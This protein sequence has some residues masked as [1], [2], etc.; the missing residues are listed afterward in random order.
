[1]VRHLW[2]GEC[3]FLSPPTLTLRGGVSCTNFRMNIIVRFY[4]QHDLDLVALAK[5]PDF[6][7]DVMMKKALRAYVRGESLTI[8]LP[9]K[10]SYRVELDSCYIH[11][12]LNHKKDADLI[13]FIKT[14]RY[15]F[16]N[17]ALKMIFRNYLEAYNMDVFFDDQNYLAKSRGVKRYEKLP[18]D[19]PV[20]RQDPRIATPPAKQYEAQRKPESPPSAKEEYNYSSIPQTEYDLSKEEDKGMEGTEFNLFSALDKL[21]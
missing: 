20:L 21:M 19:A 4:W 16:R 8:P 17:S 6:E 15:G 13:D 18:G 5:H 10:E 9:P 14:I 2:K 12:T 3:A 1:M 7:M 11:F